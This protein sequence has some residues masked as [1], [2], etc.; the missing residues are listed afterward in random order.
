V[1]TL[2]SACT[3]AQIGKEHPTGGIAWIKGCPDKEAAVTYQPTPQGAEDRSS[4]KYRIS[5][6]GSLLRIGL[7]D[8]P[9]GDLDIKLPPKDRLNKQICV[10]HAVDLKEISTSSSLPRIGL[11]DRSMPI[12]HFNLKAT[13]PNHLANAGSSARGDHV[14]IY[15]RPGSRLVYRMLQ[16]KVR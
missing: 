14:K 2:I 10:H 4:A 7:I 15:Q 13:P 5:I 1:P 11:R 9:K 6:S 12:A 8:S 16:A 3:E